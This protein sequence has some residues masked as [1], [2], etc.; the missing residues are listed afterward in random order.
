MQTAGAS[1]VWYERW[2][3]TGDERLLRDIEDYNRDD[4]ESTRQLRDW[5]LG[6]RPDGLPWAGPADDASAGTDDEKPVSNV[7]QVELRLESY[8]RRLVDALPADRAAWT[9]DHR[10]RELAWQLLDFHRRADKPGWWAHYERMD[11]SEDEL[12]DDIECLAGLQAD[13]ARPPRPE[14]KSTLYAYIVPEQESKLADGDDC[15]RTDTG[16]N[17]GRL[18]F[19]EAAGRAT[20]KL[21]PSKP[22]LPPRLSLGPG[23]PLNSRVIVDALYRFADSLLAGD[24]RYAA[25]EGLL[26]REPPRLSGR[27]A[28]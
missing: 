8:R 16:Q 9:A 10:V 27:A 24:G 12:I 26:L 25:V 14:K 20:L 11:M 13:P 5:L 22:L 6:L 23:G 18:T 4:V 15:T 21:G 2:R 3:E 7:R 17:L 28:G 1:I 19:D